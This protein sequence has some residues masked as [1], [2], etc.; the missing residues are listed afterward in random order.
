MKGEPSPGFPLR[1]DWRPSRW[2]LT[3][4][5]VLSLLAQAAVTLGGLPPMLRWLLAALALAWSLTLIRRHWS[6]PALQLEWVDPQADAQL[7]CAGQQTPAQLVAIAFRGP[8]ALVR[9]R[10]GRGRI[11]T[12]IWWPDTLPPSQRRT[13]R[14]AQS[15]RERNAMLPLVAG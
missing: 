11:Q 15:A 9:V 5:V 14:L 12:L 6:A 8:L 1:I 7:H 3:A 2:Q 4:L 10:D 13:L